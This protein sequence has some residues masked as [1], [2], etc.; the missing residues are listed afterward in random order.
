MKVIPTI[1]E[2]VANVERVSDIY[3]FLLKERVI[4][5]VGE[6][7][8]EMASL[9]VAQLLYLASIDQEEIL[10]YINS[11]GGSISA[12]LAIYDAM[13]YISN[14][15]STI[16]MGMCASM[17]SVLLCAGTA[18]KRYLLK[19]CEV[20]IHQPMGAVKGAASDMRIATSRM[21]KLQENLY[22]ILQEH[23]HQTLE[24]IRHDCDRDTYF[25]AQEAIQYGLADQ[26]ISTQ[27]MKRE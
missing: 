11:P 8:D 22:R 9:I 6:I 14:D 7:D 12:G 16:G 4:L 15:I 20:M 23:T 24:T 5:C 3:S 19:N 21:L 27:S 25:N 2:R 10:F 17:A 13:Q 18:N 26:V 1:F